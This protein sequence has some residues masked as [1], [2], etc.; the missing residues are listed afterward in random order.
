MPLAGATPEAGYDIVF[1]L[2]P[3]AVDAMQGGE[4]RKTHL[5][6]IKASG[7]DFTLTWSVVALFPDQDWAKQLNLERWAIITEIINSYGTEAYT[8]GE[9]GENVP[10]AAQ[11]VNTSSKLFVS[12]S[13]TLSLTCS[14]KVDSDVDVTFY[15]NA[16]TSFV[17]K[18]NEIIVSLLSEQPSRFRLMKLSRTGTAGGNNAK[19]LAR[20]FDMEIFDNSLQF[21]AP[22]VRPHKE[23][24]VPNMTRE[25][26]TQAQLRLSNHRWLEE[27][28]FTQ[29][30]PPCGSDTETIQ[31]PPDAVLKE[32][33]A[34]K[35][36]IHSDGYYTRPAYMF[37]AA[38]HDCATDT[39][40]APNCALTN[41]DVVRNSTRA[42]LM[43]VLENLGFALEYL[44]PGHHGLCPV[45]RTRAGKIAKYAQRVVDA[46]WPM[47]SPG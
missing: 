31:S 27:T 28:P 34:A 46:L 7:N 8:L 13:E 29:I 47:P 18:A 25:T 41:K 10:F 15:G 36:R 30:E 37:V 11:H 45:N 6:N 14:T 19:F 22:H 5:R 4:C 42:L 32:D 21:A 24:F 40:E 17:P 20:A 1:A 23:T 35:P 43:V 38:P 39:P 12:G 26:W 33:E 9:G 16:Q 44:S 3:R 2:D